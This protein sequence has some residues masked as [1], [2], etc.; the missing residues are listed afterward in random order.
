MTPRDEMSCSEAVERLWDLLDDHIGAADR[1]ALDR[2]L[3]WCV[4]CCGELAFARELRS[5]LHERARV[6]LPADARA[7]LE[8]F[9]DEVCE[10]VD[11]V[12]P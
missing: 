11:E 6:D 2:H 7:R 3:A 9:I 12:N 4:R 5:M 10:P 1:V 8:L